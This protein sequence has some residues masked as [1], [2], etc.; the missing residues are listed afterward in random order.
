MP[1]KRKPKWG[2]RTE[3]SP[4]PFK[5]NKGQLTEIKDAVCAAGKIPTDSF[6]EFIALAEDELEGYKVYRVIEDGQPKIAEV[7]AALD[8]L[9][10]TVT[11]SN[12]RYC[13]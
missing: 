9:R 4:K 10:R 3:L 13:G 11:S 5:F 2:Y 12:A 8:E 1:K 6:K 7:R